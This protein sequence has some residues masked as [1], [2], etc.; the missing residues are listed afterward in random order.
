MNICYIIFAILSILCGLLIAK[1]GKE[2]IATYIVALCLILC[3]CVSGF[4]GWHKINTT[5]HTYIVEKNSEISEGK[6][7]VMLK[8]TDSK[9]T[10]LIPVLSF[11]QANDFPEG[12]TVTLTNNEIN[13][14][15][16]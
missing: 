9:S 11:E 8:A 2:K 14:Y 6:F 13:D 1:K 10:V 12:K 15:C 4:Y 7:Q 16:K 3:G 5:P